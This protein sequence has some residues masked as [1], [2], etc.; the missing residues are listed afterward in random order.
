[1]LLPGHDGHRPQQTTRYLV[2]I[3]S[4]IGIYSYHQKPNLVLLAGHKVVPARAR[5]G[6]ERVKVPMGVKDDAIR[7][8]RPS[9]VD[10]VGRQ[11]GKLVPRRRRGE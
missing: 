9:R 2:G 5:M 4:Y 3:Y 10:G 11:D 7:P 6:D 1:M 8:G